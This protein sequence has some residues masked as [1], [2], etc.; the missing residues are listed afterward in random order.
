M[1]M[2]QAPLPECRPPSRATHTQPVLASPTLTLTGCTAPRRPLSFLS[3]PISV[4]PPPT[5]TTPCC[6]CADPAQHGGGDPALHVAPAPAWHRLI[7]GHI[8]KLYLS[9]VHGSQPRLSGKAPQLPTLWSVSPGPPPAVCC[10][11]RLLLLVKTGATVCCGLAL[12]DPRPC[13][14]LA[15]C[16]PFSS[17]RHR[18]F[19]LMVDP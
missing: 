1:R 11:A 13:A 10:Q 19:K 5:H 9:A 4:T 18:P 16:T 6:P 15:I 7:A 17:V 8:S 14:Q 2:G 12:F 3:P